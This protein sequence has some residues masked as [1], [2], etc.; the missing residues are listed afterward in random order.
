MSAPKVIVK[1]Y[2]D[3]WIVT[4]PEY[5]DGLSWSEHSTEAEAIAEATDVAEDMGYDGVQVQS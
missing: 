5:P 3:E 4:L 2:G 1:P